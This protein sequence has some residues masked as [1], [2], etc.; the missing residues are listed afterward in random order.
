MAI[1]IKSRQT[2]LFI[3][4]SITA[5]GRQ[6]MNPPIGNGYVK[7]FSDLV[8]IREP[9]KKINIINKGIGGDRICVG[10]NGRKNRGLLNRWDDD[11]LRNKPD[12][13]CIKIGINDLNSCI[14]QDAISVPP[15]LYRDSYD[16]ILARTKEFLPKCRILLIDP[17]FISTDRFEAS[18]RKEVL[19]LIPKYIKVVH[20]MSAKY[21]TRLLKTHEMFQRLL[22]HHEP[23][24]FC[25]EPIHPQLTGHLAI[26]EAVY[27]T[28]SE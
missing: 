1:K 10:M 20:E 21:K 9:G 2:I 13:L 7:L 5:A 22:K 19:D 6:N 15:E 18:Y 4:D 17:S 23:D 12:W 27:N 11:V 14:R 25:D 24:R 8:A 28:L 16:K 3:G 26:A